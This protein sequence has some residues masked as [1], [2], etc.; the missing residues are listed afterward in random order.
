MLDSL[1][2]IRIKSVIFAVNQGYVIHGPVIIVLICIEM[3]G[4]EADVSVRRPDPEFVVVCQIR[5]LVQ[6]Y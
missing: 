1:E 4:H 6:K 5:G 2:D 3:L